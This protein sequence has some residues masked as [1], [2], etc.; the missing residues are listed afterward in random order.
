MVL[1]IMRYLLLLV[2][3]SLVSCGIF[4]PCREQTDTIELVWDDP[5]YE[6]RADILADRRA[7]GWDCTE[8]EGIRNAFGKSIGTR[9]HCRMCQ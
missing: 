1:S 5:F 7:A 4:S 9:Y 6:V 2:L 8:T 3:A